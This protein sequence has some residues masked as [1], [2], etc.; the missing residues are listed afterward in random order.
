MNVLDSLFA[1]VYDPM[2]AK[3]EEKRLGEH[4][5]Q[6]LGGLSGDVLEIGA[7]TGH[8]LAAY[9]ATVRTLTLTE[10]SGPMVQR[11][12]EKAAE[13][14]PEADVVTAPAEHL[15][16]DDDSF[17]A[18][19]STLVL[20]SVTD[21]AGALREVRRVLRPGGHFAVFEH[22]AGEGRVA[23]V[24]R[25]FEPVQKVFG[26][27]CHLTRDTRQAVADAGFDVSAV[28]EMDFKPMPS[29]VRSVI[30]GVATAP[31]A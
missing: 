1:R 4:R 17:D 16:F 15:P 28:V 26:R 20:C 31:A 18:V 27:N 3:V 23:T 7:G 24:Q 29:V 22:V 11:L 2:M 25:V 6:L 14:Y 13:Q 21:T 30:S 9:P 12:R 19:V 10:P 5:R 8:N